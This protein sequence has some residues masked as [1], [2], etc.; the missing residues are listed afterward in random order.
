M[1]NECEL[2]FKK[3]RGLPGGPGDGGPGGPGDGGPGGPGD[4][5]P[6]VVVCDG[7]PEYGYGLWVLH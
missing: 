4:V 3:K 6:G 1:K 7:G 5:G 2:R